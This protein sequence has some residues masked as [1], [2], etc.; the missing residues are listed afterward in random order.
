MRME[1]DGHFT[2]VLAKSVS[3]S[4]DGTSCQITLNKKIKFS[5]GTELTADDVAFSIAAMCQI[6]EEDGSSLYLNIEGVEDFRNGSV[7]LPSGIEVPDAQS[8]DGAFCSAFAG[9]CT[10]CGVSDPE[11]TG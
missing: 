9:Q 11:T 4:E 1:G 5:D 3:M 7:E 10:D 6:A 2:G 8:C